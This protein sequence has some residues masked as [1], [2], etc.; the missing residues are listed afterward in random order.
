MS[1]IEYEIENTEEIELKREE[2]DYLDKLLG[3][4]CRSR[5]IE[6]KYK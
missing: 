6:K 1:P 2:N 4:R 3:S 5:L